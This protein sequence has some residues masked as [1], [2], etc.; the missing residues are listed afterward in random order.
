[1]APTAKL[2]GCIHGLQAYL[3]TKSQFQVKDPEHDD[4]KKIYAMLES[5]ADLEHGLMCSYLYAAYSLK[6]RW[7]EFAYMKNEEGEWVKNGRAA[8][9]Y[10]LI[11]EC[12][13]EIIA[14]AREEMMHLHFVNFLARAFGSAPRFALPSNAGKAFPM[15]FETW[16]PLGKENPPMQLDLSTLN[17]DQVL[18]FIQYECTS[19]LIGPTT[20]YIEATE[21]A[22]ALGVDPD[23]S[24]LLELINIF[25]RMYD[26]SLSLKAYYGL[27][28]TDSSDDLV[29]KF[30]H[31]V[32]NTTVS[33]QPSLLTASRPNTESSVDA[34]FLKDF[35][36]NL[37]CGI[38][39]RARERGKVK[40]L[41][42]MSRAPMEK[43]FVSIGDFYTELLKLMEKVLHE[44]PS[45][46]ELINY[47]GDAQKALDTIVFRHI[48]P[49]ERNKGCL[50]NTYSKDPVTA[51]SV[52]DI[53]ED[54]I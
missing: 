24:E 25:D 35:K 41:G 43:S 46:I 39:E 10:E 15:T 18:K 19:D 14:V 29:K 7:E 26:K 4:V 17:L 49:S 28:I 33:V 38:G 27:D 2:R 32:L 37:I 53:I 16:R 47:D 44:D 45:P 42:S 31:V 9:Q 20:R 12:R 48:I 3:T 51:Q 1:M 5:A 8:I 11:R 23:A 34:S 6:T 52:R 22:E 13:Q 30:K 50:S 40:K 36:L 21:K 54:I